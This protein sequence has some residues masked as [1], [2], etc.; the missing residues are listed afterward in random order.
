M[1]NILVVGGGG[2][3]GGALVDMLLEGGHKVLVYDNLLYESEYRKPVD[4]VFGD[5]RDPSRMNPYLEWADVVVWLAAIVGDGACAA[6][7]ELAME[8]NTKGVEWLA[9]SYD[10]R[11]IFTSTCSVYGA[12]DKVLDETSE[13]SPLSV[14][15]VSKLQA[16][17]HLLEKGGLIFRLGTLFGVGDNYARIRMD[18]VVNYLTARALFSRHITV[19][20]GDQY[21]PLLHV[22]DAARAI[23]MNLSTTHGGIFNLNAVNMPIRDL[24]EQ[25]RLHFPDL[26][27]EYTERKFQD[28]RNYRVSSEKALKTFGFIPNYTVDDGICEIRAL[29]ESGRIKDVNNPRYSNSD[30]IRNWVGLWR[31]D[32]GMG[33]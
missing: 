20:G 29:L 9:Q 19:F 17:S 31:S 2:Y 1:K 30:S 13:V 7:P 4:F 10:G 8:V 32:S 5:V 25:L 14:Y 24:G 15:A 26:K 16:E 27:T 21:R 3:I 28:N 11:I 33:R 12:S 22:K 6:N 18:L 23:F